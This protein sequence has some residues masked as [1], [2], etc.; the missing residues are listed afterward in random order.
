M[1]MIKKTWK[2]M[3]V[4][5]CRKGNPSTLLVGLQIGAAIKENSMEAPKEITIA[6]PYDPAIP[7]CKMTSPPRKNIWSPVYHSMIRESQDRQTARGAI[8]GWMERKLR[9]VY[10][11]EYFF[12]PIKGDC[13]IY[14]IIIMNLRT[15]CKI[16][17]ISQTQKQRYCI[18]PLLCAI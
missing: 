10:T 9:Y 15:S 17:K 5:V 7:L 12:S 6:L 1:A 13:V 11:L 2:R 14:N 18:I 4:R 8:D 3:S 16:S